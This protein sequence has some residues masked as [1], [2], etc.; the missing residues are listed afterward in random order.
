M[1]YK[2]FLSKKY[3][4]A[5]QFNAAKEGYPCNL[6]NVKGKRIYDLKLYGNSVQDG[7]PSPDTPI[8]IQSVGD[9]VTD[10]TSEYYGKYDIPVTSNDETVHI[11]LDEPLR[12]VGDYADYVDYKNQKV[13]RNV[14]HREF[15]SNDN[16][17]VYSS[18]ANHF[19]IRVGDNYNKSA[20]A[21]IKAMSNYYPQHSTSQ[22]STTSV[23]YAV[24]SVDGGRI[25]FRDIRCTTLDEWKTFLDNLETPLT[26]DYILATPT[27]EAITFPELTLPDSNTALIL[28]ETSV[29]A[30]NIKA[31]TYR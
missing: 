17:S 10:E 16:W 2:N 15:S 28:T 7:T 8:E 18:V 23:N 26:V 12:K 4:G 21:C 6:Q 5:F 13:V 20:V 27:E 29:P 1:S 19:Q 31:I 22:N 14:K 24:L 25:R 30:S 9:L 3:H 11:Y